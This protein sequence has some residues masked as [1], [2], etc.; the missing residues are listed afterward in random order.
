M[1]TLPTPGVAALILAADALED[2]T[3][4]AGASW[5]RTTTIEHV[6]SVVAPLFETTLVVLGSEG[7]R[8]ADSTR[9][10]D[11]IVVVDP[12]WSE[13]VSSPLRAGLDTLSRLNSVD[14]VVVID[15]VTPQIDPVVLADLLDTHLA[16]PHALPGRRIGDRAATV[17]KY[18]YSRSGPVVIARELWQRFLS[19]EGATPILQVL[20]AH[21][22]WV[23]EVWIDQLP[24]VEVHDADDLARI[25][26]RV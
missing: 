5:G 17:G 2:G 15:L 21:P 26:P 10:Q 18:R 3:S 4:R 8:V 9:L 14:H 19:M 24:P 12:E 7:D 25:A 6:V 23:A 1:A 16:T 20:S 11:A 22:E 13:G